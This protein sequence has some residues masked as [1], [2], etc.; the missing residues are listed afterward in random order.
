MSKKIIANS[1]FLCSRL[2]LLSVWVLLD[3]PSI[4]VLGLSILVARAQAQDVQRN[5]S[6][7]INTTLVSVPVVASDRQ[8]RYIAGLK[9]EDFTLYQDGLL[10]RS[11]ISV[12]RK[13]HSTWPCS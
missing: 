3:A 9:V 12:L 13:S 11:A 8:G 4:L 6:I 1:R 5:E 2:E 7:R 10:Q